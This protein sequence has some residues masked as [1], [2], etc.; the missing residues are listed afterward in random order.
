MEE[1]LT[2][3]LPVITRIDWYHGWWFA[4]VRF[5]YGGV[6]GPLHGCNGVT[7]TNEGPLNSVNLTAGELI[8][9]VQLYTTTSA[10][11]KGEAARLELKTNYR[12]IV[13][14]SPRPLEVPGDYTK[15]PLLDPVKPANCAQAAKRLIAIAGRQSQYLEALSFVWAWLPPGPPQPP[16]PP[17]PPFPHPRPPSPVPPSPPSPP[18]D[19][20][21]LLQCNQSMEYPDIINGMPLHDDVGIP[22]TI[23]NLTIPSS[24]RIRRVVSILVNVSFWH[25]RANALSLYLRPPTQLRPTGTPLKLVDREGGAG[26]YGYN[27]DYLNDGKW[28]SYYDQDLGRFVD[29]EIGTFTFTDDANSPVTTPNGVQ[30]V[31][32]GSYK[33]VNAFSTIIPAP[34]GPMVPMANTSWELTISDGSLPGFIRG[35]AITLWGDAGPTPPTPRPPNP[36]PPPRPAPLNTSQ[37]SSCVWASQAF[38]STSGTAFNDTALAAGGSKPITR[39]DWYHGWWFACVRF[40]YGGVAGPLHGC[41]GVTPTNEGPLNSVNLTSGELI[42]SVQLYTTTSA[43]GKGEAARLELKANYRTIVTGSPRPLEVP[44]DYTK[45]PLLDPPLTPASSA[46]DPRTAAATRPGQSSSCVWASQA[47]GS[48]SGTAFNDTALA[49]GGSKP[50]TQIDWYADYW[51]ACIRFYYGGEPGPLHGCNGVTPTNQG[52]VNSTYL[53]NGEL[54]QSVQLYTTTAAIGKGEAARLEL[55]TNFRTI[56]A[57]SFDPLDPDFGSEYYTKLPLLDPVKPAGCTQTSKRLIAIAGRE[58]EYVEALSF[59]WAWLPIGKLLQCNQSMEYPDIINGMPLHDDVGIPLTIPNLTIPSSCRIRRVVSISV[60]VS[61][62]HQRANALSLY[63][64]PPTQL[65]PTGTPLKLVDREGGAGPYGYNYDANRDGKLGEYYDQ[66]YGFLDYEI[67]TFTFTDDAMRYITTPT[68]L[69]M[70]VPGSYK[71]VNAFSTII[72]AP[73]GPDVPIANTTWELTISDGSLPGF[74]R[75]WAITVWGD[76]GAPPAPKPPAPKPPSPAAAVSPKPPPP[77]GPPK[78]PRP[79]RAPPSPSPAPPKPPAPSLKPPSPKQPSPSPPKATATGVQTAT[80]AGAAL[81]REAGPASAAVAAGGSDLTAAA[82]PSGGAGP[83]QADAA[84][85]AAQQQA[86]SGPA[87]GSGGGAP[88]SST[89]VVVGVV[90]GVVGTALVAVGVVAA[91]KWRRAVRSRS[92]VMPA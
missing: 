65:R 29:Y 28:G 86:G 5:Y 85:S 91:M 88:S 38:G 92:R 1:H 16:L 8:Q 59:V 41:N 62:W 45:L 27:Y 46:P 74:I 40:Y 23:P 55:Y 63:L 80:G 79:P 82:A 56:T 10:I 20:S 73:G 30:V 6:A 81:T 77:P 48:T 49:A 12:T 53:S 36:A 34:G 72:P 32:P 47:F 54:I 13:T 75:G 60:N 67:G 33:P 19:Y 87:V 51:F 66:V 22:L 43:I 35:W 61:F 37:S 68:G 21:K 84:A 31:L 83:Q 14:G 57:G 76:A 26:P 3:R 42:Q 64:R 90:C 15:L 69:Q 9:S 18:L 25:Q 50:I 70:V 52:S 7:P 58:S 24:C 2:A 71:P 44:G 17:R 89:P 78:P 39:V 4:C 11:G